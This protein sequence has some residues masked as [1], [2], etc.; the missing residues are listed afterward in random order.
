MSRQQLLGVFARWP[1]RYPRGHR[2][3]P[4][5]RCKAIRPPV[6]TGSRAD[7]RRGDRA[8]SVSRAP[9]QRLARRVRDRPVLVTLAWINRARVTA[10][11]G[12]HDVSRTHNF[13]GQRLGELKRD[14]NAKLTHR[15]ADH[16]V[17]LFVRMRAGRAHPDPAVGEVMGQRRSDGCGRRCARRRTGPLGI[18]FSTR[19]SAWATAHRRSRANRSMMTGRKFGPIVGRSPIRSTESSR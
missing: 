15:L 5:G 6:G 8:R 2:C 14:V 10:S 7:P 18:P 11:Q 12:D 9:L 3:P 4:I 17:D 13:V 1:Y 19:W 16:R